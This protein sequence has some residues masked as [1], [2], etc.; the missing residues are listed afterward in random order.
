MWMS[1]SSVRN[2]KRSC[3]ISS[4]ISPKSLLN[5]PAFVRREQA[6][7]CEHLGM[8][9]RSGDVVRKQAAIEAHTFS[10]LFDAAIG[11]LGKNPTPSL[12]RQ[13]GPRLMKK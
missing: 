9:G 7:F 13:I 10:E 3:S 2:G 8:G 6:D 5:L 12:L 11:R 4:R 1:S